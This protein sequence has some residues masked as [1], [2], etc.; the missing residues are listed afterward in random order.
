MSVIVKS[1]NDNSIE[2]Y[3]KGAPEKIKNICTN[4]PSNFDQKVN[5]LSI[6]GFRLLAIGYKK[7]NEMKEDAIAQSN[8]AQF[9]NNLQFIGFLIVDNKL[10]DDTS[11]V[12][13]ELK[14]AEYDLKVI[15]GDNPLTVI[16]TSKEAHIIDNSRTMYVLDM[17]DTG[18]MLQLNNIE[19]TG[20]TSRKLENL[21]DLHQLIM[22]S[23]IYLAVTG[24]AFNYIRD[25]S[26]KN[27][28]RKLL[29]GIVSKAQLFTRFKPQNKADIIKLLKQNKQQV[30]M[31]GDGSNDSLAIREAD[32]GISFTS[33]D[34]S[35]ASPFSSRSN[36]IDCV[37]QVL[38]EG[39]NMYMICCEIMLYQAVNTMVRFAFLEIV[40]L[41]Y[42]W[43]TDF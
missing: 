36:S 38:L 32:L 41:N 24:Y 10:K 40:S 42:T 14:S 12:I 27:N 2:Y 1:E 30:A 43:I 39:K 25:N 21:S 16:S 18:K 7:L 35:F 13:D 34:A 22:E 15:S 8:R 6:Q 11:K 28:D 31:V 20:I 29:N 17:D 33:A 37:K 26:I 23:N 9:E 4:L 5:E 3:I 19:A